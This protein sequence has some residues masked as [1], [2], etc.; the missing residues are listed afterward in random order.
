MQESSISRRNVRHG[1][2]LD[3]PVIAF[4]RSQQLAVRLLS[5][6]SV[7]NMDDILLRLWAKTVKADD[8]AYHPLLFH[9]LDVAAVA[10]VMWDEWMPWPVKERIAA[11]FGTSPASARLA[12]VLLAG[13]HDLG[14]ACPPFQRQAK[15]LFEHLGLPDTNLLH[16]YAPH[17]FVSA[18]ELKRMLENGALGWSADKEAAYCL[19][20]I[21]GGH[22]G[23][24]PSPLDLGNLSYR[25]AG[26]GESAWGEAR[27]ALVARFIELVAGPGSLAGLR[28]EK[29]ADGGSV[30]IVAGLI[31]V[32]DWIGSAQDRFP[33]A[34]RVGEP[35]AAPAAYWAEAR[36]R[37]ESALR[38]FGWLPAPVPAPPATL[39]SVF[40][41]IAGFT[42]NRMQRTVACLV[43]DAEWP[44]LMII[45][46]AMGRGKSEAGFYVFDYAFTHGMT[47]GFF[48]GLPTMAT[49]NA[50][51]KR[52]RTFLEKRGH[53]GKLN[54]QLIHGGALL[55]EEFY[56][57]TLTPVY[58]ESALKNDAGNPADPTGGVLAAEQWFTGRKRALLAP[59]GAGTIDQSL[60][61]VLQTKH[62]FVRL[63]GIT[64]KVVVFDEVHAYDTYMLTE[65][66]RLIRWLRELGCSVVLLSA[67]LPSHRRAD[68]IEAWRPGADAAGLTASYP[69]VTLADRA[70]ARG[71]E[72]GESSPFDRNV[73]LEFDDPSPERM[74][75]HVERNLP[76][77]GC[78]VVICNTVARA[79]AMY[80]E[81]ECVFAK[82][83]WTVI[84]FHARIPMCWRDQREQQVLELLGRGGERGHTLV[85]GTQVLEQS[86][87][88]D[89]DWMAVDICPVDLLLQRIGRLWRHMLDL[90][91]ERRPCVAPRVTVLCADATE[92]APPN[93]ENAP[94]AIYDRYIMLRTWLALAA[95]CSNG[96]AAM[97][98]LPGDIEPLVERVYTEAE[99]GDL[100]E[101]WSAALA[102]EKKKSVAARDR[103]SSLAENNLVPEPDLPRHLLTHANKQL[104][105]DEDPRL[106]NLVQAMTRLGD[107]SVTV[108]CCGTATGGSSLA[109]LTEAPPTPRETRE[110]MR[111]SIRLQ[112][113]RV[114]HD[115]VD[116]PAPDPW[117]KNAHLRYCRALVFTDGAAQVGR[118]ILR[119]S[120]EQGLVI[121]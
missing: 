97:V 100:A 121:E 31:S 82:R 52:E 44:F 87:D 41:Y 101:N 86:L 33:A 81:L 54:L 51:F 72:V 40:Q 17:G 62:W 59:F 88:Y 15:A 103:D 1:K 2:S 58:D 8:R 28:T 21:T 71:I 13:L 67:T 99:P 64:G 26:P 119:L 57:L 83:G 74:V 35:V 104:D 80:G 96:R 75:G 19:A 109:S 110:L 95:Q 49:G 4:G 65:L 102:A 69:R 120:E 73:E 29:L 37:A 108:I 89:A 79:Q 46:E 98:A 34:A 39:E 55:N 25:V 42:P 60:L 68:F 53:A 116:L 76:N 24:F 50:M 93:L 92:E 18:N 47:H 23:V 32:A 91:A 107:P 114:Y 11:A 48:C 63:L 84:L 90:P 111:F 6:P 30:P 3:A 66:A 12:F 70:G 20:A 61:G 94:A 115:L 38:E 7:E 112:S 22:H 14:K 45:E 5:K 9:M 43:E 27:T 77:G 10:A 113:R 36:E 106:H 78:G 56:R 117:R 16:P 85:I 118:H 105:D